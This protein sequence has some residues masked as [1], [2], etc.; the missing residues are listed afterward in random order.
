MPNTRLHRVGN[1]FLGQCVRF[2]N[3]IPL[4]IQEF[5]IT[6]FKNYMK[7]KLQNKGYYTINDYLND[8]NPWE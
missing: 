6:K 8:N 7:Q 1:S 3:K 5:S 4:D 2:Y